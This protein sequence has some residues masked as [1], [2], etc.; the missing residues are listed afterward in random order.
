VVSHFAAKDYDPLV[1]NTILLDTIATWSDLYGAAVLTPEMAWSKAK[2]DSY[3]NNLVARKVRLAR[4]FPQSHNFSLS[5][6]CSRNM[7]E[8]LVER[9]LPV[10]LW[11]TQVT[12]GAVYWLCA[13]YPELP[14]IIEA[15]ARKI[16]YHD[17]DYY[18]LLAE[19]PNLFLGL[20][21]LVNGCGIEDIVGRYGSSRLIF[22]SNLP[23]WNPNSA[24][25]MLSL[26]RISQADKERI[27][28]GNLD[29]LV[30][31]VRL[32]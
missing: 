26:A 32:P 15:G 17:R 22:G 31:G 12:W 8:A 1:G 25:A 6:W 7:L 30:A 3:L 24:I 21:G 18:H 11:H 19:L 20:H 16:F 5:E 2:F 10:V 28:Y 4:L 23:V 13:T 29:D 9:C 27:A 14:V